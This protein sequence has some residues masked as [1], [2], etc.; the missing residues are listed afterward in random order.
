VRVRVAPVEPGTAGAQTPTA[1]KWW[2]SA[3]GWRSVAPEYPKLVYYWLR[4]N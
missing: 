1:A 2:L 4:Y 3:R